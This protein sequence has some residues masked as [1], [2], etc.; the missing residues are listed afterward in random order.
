MN[1]DVTIM[2]ISSRPDDNPHHVYVTYLENNSQVGRVLFYSG[3][4][5][6]VPELKVFEFM[7]SGT[8]LHSLQLLN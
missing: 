3:I 8:Q 4:D 6:D 5:A 1:T 7:S 2:G